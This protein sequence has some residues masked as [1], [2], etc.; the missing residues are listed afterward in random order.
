MTAEC[1][2]KKVD[3]PV[4]LALQL[5]DDLRPLGAKSIR[6]RA[7]EGVDSEGNQQVFR[8]RKNVSEHNQSLH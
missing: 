1:K 4:C 6:T 7:D 2:A 5:S 3:G 8:S